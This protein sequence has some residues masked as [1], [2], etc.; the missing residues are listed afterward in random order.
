[1]YD[2]TGFLGRD[3]AAYRRQAWNFMLSGGGAFDALDYSFTPGH[4][5]G[6]DTAPNGPGGGS[7]ELRRE[8]RVLSEFVNGL[9]LAHMR[10][11][12]SVVASAPG[13]VAHA[14]AWTGETYAVY[15]DERGPVTV[16]L[17]LPSGVYTARWI[18]VMDGSDTGAQ[19]VKADGTATA[20]RSPE[21]A[22]GIALRIERERASST[23]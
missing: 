6:T 16:Q 12:A 21:F 3:D 13:V 19:E 20:L 10:A 15:F 8:L 4:E 17:A 9:P 14:L 22:D 5:D 7:P 2:E 18:S 1:A 11:D 23:H